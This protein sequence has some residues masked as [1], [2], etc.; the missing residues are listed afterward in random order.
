MILMINEEEIFREKIP[1]LDDSMVLVGT[2]AAVLIGTRTERKICF[3][4]FRKTKES[5]EKMYDVCEFKNG[6]IRHSRYERIFASEGTPA[7]SLTESMLSLNDAEKLCVSI[8]HTHDITS[9]SNIIQDPFW[10]RIIDY[11]KIEDVMAS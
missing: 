11:M 8:I 3:A 1:W 2:R 4:I 9:I 6:R 10:Q 5:E 7:S